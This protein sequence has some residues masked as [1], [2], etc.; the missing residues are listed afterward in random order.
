MKKIVTVLVL[1][2]IFIAVPI[3][4]QKLPKP[5]GYI[6]DFAGVID[7]SYKTQMERIIQA[8]QEKTG[9]EIAV[10]TVQSIEP[11]GSI[12]E[13]SIDL[14]TEWGIGKK[15][16]DTGVLLVLA[17]KERRLRLEVGYGLEGAI[18]DGLAGEIMD[19]SIIPSFQAGDY[20]G[21]F[22]KGVQAVSGIIA[23]EYDVDLSS[24]DLQ[25]SRKY[26]RTGIPGLGYLIFIIIALLFGGGR[27]LWPLIFLGG[28]TRRGFYGGGF[29]SGGSSF[30]GGFSGFGG[31]GFGGGGATRGF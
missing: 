24:Y 6:N 28:M 12:E 1:L 21:G 9:A 2:L 11:Y 3:F 17:M 20:G 25:E 10:V 23:K 16:E 15:G 22:L 5:V 26:T 19:K 27:F 7:A 8:V 31:G 13:Y 30:G 29:G 14:A 4:A 18:P